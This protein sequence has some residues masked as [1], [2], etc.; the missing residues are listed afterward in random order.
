MTIEKIKFLHYIKYAV[1]FVIMHFEL[2]V[3]KICWEIAK[4]F[5]AE[6]GL[7]LCNCKTLIIDI[8]LFDTF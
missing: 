2:V 1:D 7:N 5:L 3:I 6:R 4:D 8:C